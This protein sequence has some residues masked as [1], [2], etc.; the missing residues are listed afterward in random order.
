M[1]HQSICPW[2]DENGP[3]LSKQWRIAS[4]VK[5]SKKYGPRGVAGE[6]WSLARNVSHRKRRNVRRAA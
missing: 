2:I 5:A 3:F 4:T 6:P 1:A